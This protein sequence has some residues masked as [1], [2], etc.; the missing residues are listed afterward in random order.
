MFWVEFLESHNEVFT[1]K[2]IWCLGFAL[3]YLGRE[4]LVEDMDKMR[5]AMCD[6]S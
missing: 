2:I 1:D 3:K 4:M 6:K 5:L